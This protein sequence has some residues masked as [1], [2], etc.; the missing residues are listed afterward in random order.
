MRNFAFH[1]PTK[2]YFGKGQLA[3]LD[4]A[5][6]RDGVILMLYG[7]GSIKRNGVYDQVRQALGA[8]A[9][10]EYGGFDFS[11]GFGSCHTSGLGSYFNDTYWN[12]S[13]EQYRTVEDF[14]PLVKDEQLEFE[15][16]ARF[17]YSNTGMLLL[18]VVI[19]SATGQSYFD[20]IRE[21]IYAPAGMTH[22]DS[23]EM[24]Y[25]VENLAIGYIPDRD[26]EYGWQNNVFKHVIK[27]GPAGGG[28]STVGDLHRFAR[29][30]QT[31]ALV[32]DASL[33]TMWT[34]QSGAGYGYG[35]QIQQGPAGTV[36]GHGGGFPG[37]NGNL[38]IFVDQG[39]IVAVLAN[40]D[41]AASPVADRIHQLIAR[42]TV[43][44]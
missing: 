29:A 32:S 20:Y 9:V 36:V 18:G 42:T 38:D 23:Y 10:L 22:S 2:I 17:R 14:K 30:L 24:D 1:N 44:N 26:S 19:E 7:G 16:G 35:F 3:K 5:V 6:P 12:G 13:R 37:L 40:Y 28:F 21:N 8:R 34:D 4:E 31:G 39:Y 27:G 15:P 41:R 33:A 43:E 25:P 11:K